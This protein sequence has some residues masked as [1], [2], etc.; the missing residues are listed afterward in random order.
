MFFSNFFKKRK[1]KDSIQQ[2]Y[3]ALIQIILNSPLWDGS[4]EQIYQ[5]LPKDLNSK[6]IEYV[7]NQATTI[8]T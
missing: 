8:N 5:S 1:E 2:E 4:D 7:K 6:T 3:V